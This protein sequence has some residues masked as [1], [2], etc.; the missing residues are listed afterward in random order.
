M[1]LE[2]QKDGDSGFHHKKKNLVDLCIALKKKSHSWNLKIY[3][4]KKSLVH[5]PR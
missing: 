3:R 5:Q 2:D 4:N 1:R